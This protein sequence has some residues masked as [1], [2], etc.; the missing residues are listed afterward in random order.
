MLKQQD[1][2]GFRTDFSPIFILYIG[3]I[4]YYRKLSFFCFLR[5]WE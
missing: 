5:R 4:C 1:D 3:C 2:L